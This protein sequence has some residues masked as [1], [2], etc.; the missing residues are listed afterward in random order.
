MVS[1]R[2]PC[3]IA[4]QDHQPVGKHTGKVLAQRVA[5]IGQVALAAAPV[6][7]MQGGERRVSVRDVSVWR[8]RGNRC[9]PDRHSQADPGM[10]LADGGAGLVQAHPHVVAGIADG[11]VVQVYLLGLMLAMGQQ[12]FGKLFKLALVHGIRKLT[13]GCEQNNPPAMPA[14]CLNLLNNFL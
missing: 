12:P 13:T 2:N 7:H 11:Q 6:D 14:G 3:R 8:V 10:A 4:G 1:C 5:E 9:G